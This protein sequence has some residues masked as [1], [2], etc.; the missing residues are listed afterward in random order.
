MLQKA[1]TSNRLGNPELMLQIFKLPW[2]LC[3]ESNDASPKH[4]YQSLQGAGA[5]HRQFSE[6][7]RQ[8]AEHCPPEAL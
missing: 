3:E 2:G 1:T 5:F 4:N 7:Q 6:C 8:L